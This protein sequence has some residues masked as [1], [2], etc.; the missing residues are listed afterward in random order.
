MIMALG[1]PYEE[2]IF[3]LTNL[4]TSEW[5]FVLVGIAFTHLDTK[6]I[7]TRIYSFSSECEKGLMKSKHNHPSTRH[8]GCLKSKD[9][10][11]NCDTN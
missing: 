8:L 10:V 7:A 9:Y 3:L 11:H 4:S 1:H 2:K 6:L 5:L